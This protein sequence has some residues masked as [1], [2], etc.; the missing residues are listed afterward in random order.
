[1]WTMTRLHHTCIETVVVVKSTQRSPL[2]FYKDGLKK[3]LSV[4]LFWAVYIAYRILSCNAQKT[5]HLK[6]IHTI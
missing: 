3:E 2:I 1:M 5:Y 4:N 6:Y